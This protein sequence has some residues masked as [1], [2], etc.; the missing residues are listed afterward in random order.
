MALKYIH[1]LLLVDDE[2]SII[3]SLQRIFRKE[4]YETY[5]A[6]SGQ[7]GLKRL[8]E[9]EK[10]FSLIVSDQRMPEM[11]GAQ[12][13]EKAKKI[14]PHAIRILL[15]GYSDMDAI[16]GAVNKGEIHRYLTKPWNDDDLLLQVRQALEQYE[17]VVENRR[18]LALT[19]KQNKE[20]SELNK[21]LEEKVAERSR[22]IGEKN[23]ELSR[24][25]RELESSLYNSLRAFASLVEMHT[26]ALAGHG[27]R[28]GVFSRQIAML[29]DLPED[30]VTQ[31]EIAGLLHDIGKF[32]FR[33]KLLD[34]EEDRWTMADNELFH[35]HP[36]RGQ[37]TVQFI[38]KLENVGLMIRSHHEEYNGQGY[39][40][41]LAGEE[42]PLGARIIAVVDAYDKIVN[43]KL[44]VDRSFEGVARAS[45]V[46]Q[47]QDYS[48]EDEVLQRAAILHLKQDDFTRYD[49]SVVKLFLRVLKAT[50]I[51]YAM[52]KELS[53]ENL[54]EGMVLSRSLYSSSG[55]FLLSHNTTLTKNHI[56]K[57]TALHESDPITENIYVVEN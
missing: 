9:A 13:L 7:E 18:L 33:Q 32:G 1:T 14:F 10:P 50:G 34:Y 3:K 12:F 21:H 17:L 22:E 2:E 53:V 37:A 36:E 39:P 29:L 49:A 54:R 57:L 27:R 51:L 42:I 24:L 52:E 5:T 25:N 28:V 38:D 30:E 40:D 23:K 47:A 16:V 45:K 31:I 11:T 8:K 35:K 20:L 56:S 48:T 19:K 44:G 43:L 6:L 4:G 55:Q 15:T 46:A 41:Q 26:P